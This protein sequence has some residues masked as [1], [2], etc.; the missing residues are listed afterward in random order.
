MVV[1]PASV[2]RGAATL[3]ATPGLTLDVKDVLTTEYA[4]RIKL[5]P[6]TSPVP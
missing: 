2:Q 5:H 6:K 1:G 3:P 4:E